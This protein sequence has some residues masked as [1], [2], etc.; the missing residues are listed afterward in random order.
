MIAWILLYTFSMDRSE[1]VHSSSADAH[2]K[3]AGIIIDTSKIE[4]F[5]LDCRIRA[6][7]PLSADECWFAGSRGQYGFTKDAGKTWNIDSIRH[8][9]HGELEFRSMAITKDALLLLSIG[10]PSLLYRSIDQGMSWEVVYREDDSLAF[11]N[12]LA[13]WNDQDGIAM[14]DP[15]SACM[16][17]IL[18]RDGGKNWAKIPCDRLP[19]TKQGEAAFAASNSNL[20]LYADH[21]WM[22]SGGAEAR[23][24]HS[25]DK[26]QNWQVYETP[27]VEGGRMTGIFSC[28]FFNADTGIII[29]GDWEAMSMKSNNKA[30]TYDGGK[31]WEL[32]A[33]GQSPGYRSCVQFLSDTTPKEIIAVGIPG[34]SITNDR[35]TTWE[36]ISS[37]SFYTVR[38]AENALWFGRVNGMARLE[39]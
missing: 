26:G 18:T 39:F 38:R 1:V 21:V 28:D 23:V 9:N 11:Y 36:N 20:A 27:I 13:F 35:G 32:I 33:Q 31:N 7:F 6:I 10:S 4:Y 3:E 8:D 37:Q 29:G 15:T 30:V 14:G 22:V 25:P 5:D 19:K 34:I 24:F 2:F 16:S 12:S 17:V